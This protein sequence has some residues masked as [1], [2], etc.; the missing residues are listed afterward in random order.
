MPDA[1]NPDGLTDDAVKESMRPDDDLFVR[2]GRILGDVV[3]EVG[4]S[5]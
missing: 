5:L 2:A 1:Y 4:E 3:A